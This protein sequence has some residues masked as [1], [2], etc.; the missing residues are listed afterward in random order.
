MDTFQ[1]ACLLASLGELQQ[2]I[3]EREGM[4]AANQT[5]LASGSLPQYDQADFDNLA[6]RMGYCIPNLANFQS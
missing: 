3:T 5:R 6:E 4:V 1:L 2:R